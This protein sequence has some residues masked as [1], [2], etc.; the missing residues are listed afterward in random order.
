[1]REACFMMDLRRMLPLAALATLLLHAPNFARGEE[2]AAA[3]KSN[4]PQ[5]NRAAFR[6]ALDVGHTADVPGAISARGV[7][8][9]DFNLRLGK[10]IEKNLT[11]AGFTNAVLFVTADAPTPGLFKRVARANAWPADVFL[12]IHHDSVPDYL[13]ET[14]EYQGEEHHFSDRYPGFALFVSY[15]NVERKGSLLFGKFLGEQM[16]AR[17][18]QFTPHYTDA[19]MRNKR[20]E[21]V[22]PKAGV[23]RYDQLIVLWYTHM[24]ALL[25]E[26]GSIVNRDEELQ[27]ATPERQALIG[28]AVTQAV[29]K[30]C[31]SRNPATATRSHTSPAAKPA[32]RPAARIRQAYP[33]ADR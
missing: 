10:Q 2:A 18:L 19:I 5:C 21:L 1:M 27:L 24:P 23:Y 8:E 28:T 16:Q 32:N 3:A 14:W 12:S 17:G 9:Y 33:P 6:V 30:F 4:H 31:A 11:E 15:N 22:D 7:S 20:R 25:L 13:M 26:A 29:E